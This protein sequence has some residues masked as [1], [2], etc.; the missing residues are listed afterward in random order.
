VLIKGIFREKGVERY[1]RATDG[2][3]DASQGVCRHFSLRLHGIFT[4]SFL[5]EIDFPDLHALSSCVSY[6]LFNQTDTLVAADPAELTAAKQLLNIS[7][8]LEGAMGYGTSAFAEAHRFDQSG[9]SCRIIAA[10]AGH[11]TTVPRRQV[12]AGFRTI[13]DPI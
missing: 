4:Q 6:K 9:A 7:S 5:K 2:V 3:L 13:V 11:G 1:Q 8:A 10:C 12:G